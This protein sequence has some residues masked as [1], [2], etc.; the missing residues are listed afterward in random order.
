LDW[1]GI[2]N[3]NIR[4]QFITALKM[5]AR[6]E[7][8]IV[9]PKNLIQF[10]NKLIDINT[11]EEVEASTK[12]FLTTP[13][14]HNLGCS[15]DVPMID[16][17]I[18]EWVGV[19]KKEFMYEIIAYCLLKDYPIQ[20]ILVLIGSGG[21]GKGR[22]LELL[23]NFLGQKNVTNTDIDRIS[24][25]R[26]ETSKLLNKLACEIAETNITNIRYTSTLKRL[27]GG[28]LITCEF[29]NK[30]PFDFVNYA[31]LIV[32]TNSLPMT[33]DRTIGFY[34]RWSIVE[35]PNKFEDG[36]NII[37][38]IPEIEYENLGFKC[39]N[40]LRRLIERGSFCY[41]GGDKWKKEQYEKYSNPIRTFIN[42]FFEKDYE[43]FIPKMEF[44]D[45]FYNFL[46]DNGYRHLSEIEIN[47]AL[48][49]IGFE[50]QTKN[51]SGKNLKCV[52]G[53]KKIHPSSSN[54]PA[55]EFFG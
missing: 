18:T 38:T 13:V 15:E 4:S 39:I 25:N 51:V 55:D 46:N 54:E 49:A 20:R 37:E 27:C 10:K 29:K 33:S 47:K 31:K 9:P 12:Y 40:L 30:N 52:L 8:P 28:D 1:N 23:R 50:I 6:R 34:R 2:L 14:P 24:I 17:L 41:D 32:A 5:I 19:E 48:R 16:K 42:T 3:N 44:N 45:L 43:G 35:F 22:F 11:G 21:N 53:L 36:K 26:F 7:S